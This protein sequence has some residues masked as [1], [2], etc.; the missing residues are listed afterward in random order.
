MKF[1]RRKRRQREALVELTNTLKQQAEAMKQLRKEMEA[2]NRAH[3]TSTSLRE[4]QRAL[5]DLISGQLGAASG[6]RPTTG[7]G[8][9]A[10]Y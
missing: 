9:V 3:A 5:A 10:R 2:H 6:R 7:D 1:L 4:A 8:K